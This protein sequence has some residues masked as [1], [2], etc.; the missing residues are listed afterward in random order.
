MG[1]YIRKSVG[2]GPI[3]FNISKSGVGVSFGVKGAR[4]STG[5]RGTY[6]NIGSHGIYYRQ[7]IGGSIESQ[8]AIPSDNIGGD[9]NIT[10][11][12]F[13]VNLENLADSSSKELLDKI[14]SRIRQ[15]RYAFLI[16]CISTVIAG[17]IV[18]FG[19]I[20]QNLQS[21]FSLVWLFFFGIAM[22]F[23]GLGLWVAWVTSQQ[24]KLSH[25]TTLKYSLDEKAKENFIS[26][27]AA[28]RDLSKSTRVWLL[29]SKA[30]NFD[31]K[32]NAGASSLISR[33]RA[34]IKQIAPPFIQTRI[35][36]F[37]LSLNSTQLFFLPDQVFVFQNGKYGALSYGSLKIDEMPARFIEDEAVP[38]DSRVVDTTWQYIRKDG[39]PDLRFKN[40]RQLP[41][42]Q[43]GYF[44]ISSS[45]GLHLRFY[46]SN[47]EYAK[48]F[49]QVLTG[50]GKYSQSLI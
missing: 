49:A 14:N 34:E 27:Q 46:V 47:L 16:G 17:G 29:T 28:L 23:W 12:K 25:T 45:T 33:T 13:E 31:W 5:P 43:Y 50:Y 41:V 48:Q 2:F 3:R 1:F 18:L 7:K 39:G 32:R 11:E 10:S 36:V 6:V 22:V 4:L 21:A 30:A 44:E 19:S 40:N 24:E 8:S 42:V 9:F 37:S 35:K 38:S 20:I 15:P 26:I